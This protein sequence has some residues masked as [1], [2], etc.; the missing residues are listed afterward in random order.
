MLNL[1]KIMVF[2]IYH[3]TFFFPW[4]RDF[5][6]SLNFGM[7]SNHKNGS[8]GHIL[9]HNRAIHPLGLTLRDHA[10]VDR[11][12]EGELGLSSWLSCVIMTNLFFCWSSVSP[13][14]KWGQ[15]VDS[16]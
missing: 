1:E 3:L 14:V 6:Q 8:T 16:V 5:F 4:K 12:L 10:T 13:A 11:L 15:W 7:Y 2:L 9:Q